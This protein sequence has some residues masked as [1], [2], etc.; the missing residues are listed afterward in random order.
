MSNG[1]KNT[2]AQRKKFPQLH[3]SEGHCSRDIRK[4]F[5]WTRCRTFMTLITNGKTPLHCPYYR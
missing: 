5:E 2:D 4:G 1:R 3:C